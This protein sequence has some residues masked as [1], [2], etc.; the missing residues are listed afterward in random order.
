MEIERVIFYPDHIEVCFENEKVTTITPDRE[1]NLKDILENMG[2]M[3][4]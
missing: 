3:V 4:Y 2:V 1:L